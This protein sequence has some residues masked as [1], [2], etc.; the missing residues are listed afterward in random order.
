VL[1]SPGTLREAT[2]LAPVYDP[3]GLSVQ[4]GDIVAALEAY[5]PKESHASG[6]S[7]HV[8]VRWH[9]DD[10]QVVRVQEG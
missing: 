3:G 7:Q 6:P 4:H 9:W 1:P 8:T 2:I 10:R 5:G